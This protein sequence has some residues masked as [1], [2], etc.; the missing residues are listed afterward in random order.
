MDIL[1]LSLFT[2]DFE[3][4]AMVK[5]LLLVPLKDVLKPVHRALGNIC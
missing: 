1:D 5:T 2:I 4:Q 3:N